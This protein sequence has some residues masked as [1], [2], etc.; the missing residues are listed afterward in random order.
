[1]RKEAPAIDGSHDGRGARYSPKDMVAAVLDTGIYSRHR[2]LDEGKVLA[3]ADCSTL[4]RC[5]L[6]SP[7]N[8][9]GHGP[10][11]AG[12]L[13]GDGDGNPPHKGVSPGAGLVGV[14]VLDS[15]GSGSTSSVLRGID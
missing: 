10:H 15:N 7:Y 3:F 14:K 8:D 2:D 5:R 12:T 1:V 9:Y 13:A 6:H 11:V 4:S